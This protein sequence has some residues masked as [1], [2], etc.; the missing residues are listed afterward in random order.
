MSRI[1]DLAIG[2][3]A[4]AAI[5][6]TVLANAQN[7]PTMD[8]LKISPQYYSLRLEND[9]VRVYEWRLKPGGKEA[10]HS[11]PDGLVIALADATLKSTLPDGTSMTRATTN[12]EVTWRNALTHSLENVGTTEAHVIAV[13]LKGGAK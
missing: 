7:T 13:E 12:G 1:A 11:H 2:A 8:P 3:V 4:G 5:S 6:A 10:A 9:R